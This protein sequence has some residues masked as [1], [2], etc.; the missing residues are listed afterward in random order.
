MSFR[1]W[2]SEKQYKRVQDTPT[3]MQ[4]EIDQINKDS[5]SCFYKNVLG[6][7]STFMILYI[8]GVIYIYV[9][10]WLVSCIY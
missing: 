8:C 1:V 5:K 10:V 3:R 2:E 6:C 9:Y 7:E 4:A